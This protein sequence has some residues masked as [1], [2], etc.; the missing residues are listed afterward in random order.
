M[1]QPIDGIDST[2]RDLFQNARKVLA[3]GLSRNTIN[4]HP[5]PDYADFGEGC[6]VTDVD[7][8]CRVD[9]ANNMASLIH[10]HADPD[11]IQA[12]TSQLH[13]GTAFTMAT[14][15]ELQL[16]EL[17]CCRVPWFDKVRFMN[18]GSEAVMAAIKA[19]RAFT[20]RPAIAKV[21]GA[22]H[23]TYDYAE[24]SQN[25]SPKNWGDKDQPN[26]VPVSTG[27]P[28]RALNDVVVL[29]FN[30]IDVSI[31]LLNERADEIACV[32]LDLLPH[33]L[34]LVAASHDYVDALRK[35]TREHRCLLV[36]DEV[37]TFRLNYQGAAEIYSARPDLTTLGKIIG[38]GFPVGALA[39]TDEVMQLLDPRQESVPFPFSGT[40]SANP[41]T[42]TAGRV[43]LEKFDQTA[44]NRLNQLGQSA[45]E[46]LTQVVQKMDLPVCITGEG[47]MFRIMMRETP[48]TNFR[49]AWQTETQRTRTNALVDFLYQHGFMLFRTCTAALS[50]ATTENEISKFVDTVQYGLQSIENLF[51]K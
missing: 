43:A 7:G 44:I 16:A 20:N 21:E 8:N 12:V 50:T 37:I 18:S 25:A 46:Q 34:G 14:E 31:K 38:G 42:M 30:D 22:Y 5:H 17:L 27:T 36:F 1:D 49:E 29:P 26:S 23:G 2:S 28:Q 33:R 11:I 13:R 45:R 6:Y 48:P 9:F 51:H 3:G 40:F 35:W 39:G 47:S 19:A 41:I 32:M 10:G 15:A 24:V 4:R